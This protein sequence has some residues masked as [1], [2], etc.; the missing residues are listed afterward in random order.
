MDVRRVLCFCLLAL[1]LTALGP[2]PG[3]ASPA[4]GPGAP[5]A[6][7][8]APAPGPRSTAA[9]GGTAAAPWAR[10]IVPSGPPAPILPL[11][12]VRPG[13]EGYAL[14]VFSGTKPERFKVRVVAVMRAFLPK[15]D[16]ILIRA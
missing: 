13:M 1:V 8:S 9:V 2:G 10:A 12:D 6:A 7:T 4:A 3:I 15:E 5:A 11:S 16:V 14:T